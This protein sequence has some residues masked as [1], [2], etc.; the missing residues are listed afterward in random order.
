[1]GNRLTKIY[2]RTGD[3]GE[4]G[5]ADG[6]RIAKDDILIHVQG[7]VDELNSLLGLLLSKLSTENEKQ[8]ILNIQH[9]LF[10]LGAEI[11][12]AQNMINADRVLWLEAKLDKINVTLPVLKEFILPGGSEVVAV[13]HL[14]RSVCRRC[15]RNF[16]TLSRDKKTNP[17][18]MAYLNRLSDFL[19]VFARAIIK[20]DGSEEIY[21]NS[22]RMN[23]ET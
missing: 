16:I 15:E 1:M 8:I 11:S 3:A 23:E 10:D 12:L 9:D 22:E 14:A 2:T 13:C 7:D 6:S 18:S 19:F 17:E 20:I 5:T 4:T 21:W